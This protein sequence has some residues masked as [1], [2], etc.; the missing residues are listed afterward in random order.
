WES[1]SPGQGK[2]PAQSRPR[3]PARYITQMAP[4]SPVIATWEPD[5]IARIGRGENLQVAPGVWR[6]DAP[7]RTRRDLLAVVHRN[8]RGVSASRKDRLRNPPQPHRERIPGDGL[9]GEREGDEH[10]RGPRVS[11]R[12]RDSRSSGSRDHHRT[13][14]RRPRDRDLGPREIPGHRLREILLAGEQG[15]GKPQRSPSNVARRPGHETDPRVHRE[16]RQPE[17]LRP[18]RP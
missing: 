3:S 15:P 11:E 12:P 5:N 17:E 4:L 13:G 10:P 6:L 7:K 2:S 8:R 14:R 16:L 18:N 1:E 9:P